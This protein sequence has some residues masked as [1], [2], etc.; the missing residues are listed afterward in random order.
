MKDRLFFDT[1]IIYYAYDTSEP[2]K[3]KIC[4]ELLEKVFSGD[5]I[6]IVSGQILGELFNASINKLDIP[7]D[8]AKV[9]VQALI[10]SER[11]EKI[12][13]DQRT[14][15]RAISNFEDVKVPFWDLVISETM[16]EN[17]ITEIITENEK[18]FKKIRG[19]NVINP[20]K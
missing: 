7:L 10:T 6:G 16:K 11:W 20:F 8:K 3:R 14:I 15:I 9:I 17:N 18:D 12:N 4:Q 19:I 1:N 2:Q 13:Y 5:I